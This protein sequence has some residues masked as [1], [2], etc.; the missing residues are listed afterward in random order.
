MDRIEEFDRKV[1]DLHTTLEAATKQ[2]KL[3]RT[4]VY[5]RL[6]TRAF[7]MFVRYMERAIEKYERLP[8]D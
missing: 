2:L 6:R 3:S 8:D 5:S 7:E 4:G 1:D